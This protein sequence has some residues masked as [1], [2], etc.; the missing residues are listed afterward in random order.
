MKKALSVIFAALIIVF[1]LAPFAAA[2]ENE[3]MI[4]LHFHSDI[5]GADCT[6]LEKLVTVES[7]NLVLTADNVFLSD[8]AGNRYY[9]KLKPGR[10]YSIYYEFAPAGGFEIPDVLD[11]GNY[12]AE[13]DGG[14][15]VWASLVSKGVYGGGEE[16]SF[17]LVYTEVTVDGN[18][19]ERIFGRI[20][21]WFVKLRA[22]SPY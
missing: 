20:A 18:L 19:F 15:T 5:A 22:W 9:D 4:T 16:Y 2:Q 11:E 7:G 14:C 13:C 1:S 6:E 10:N 12:R 21:D 3:E 8:H 17:I